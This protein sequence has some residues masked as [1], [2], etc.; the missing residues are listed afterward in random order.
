MHCPQCG[1][2]MPEGAKFCGVCGQRIEAED[3]TRVQGAPVP[4]TASQPGPTPSPAPVQPIPGYAAPTPPYAAPMVEA[5]PL[6]RAWADFRASFTGAALAKLMLISILPV[7]NLCNDGLYLRWGEDAVH[8]GH[9]PVPREMLANGDFAWG[10]KS[11]LVGFVWPLIGLFLLVVPVLGWVLFV[12]WLALVPCIGIA[13]ALRAY[14]RDDLAAGFDFA[15]V[16]RG[17][18]RRFGQLW[19]TVFLPSLA[20]FGIML[21][22]CL[23]FGGVL[24]GSA[25]SILGRVAYGSSSSLGSVMGLLGSSGAILLLVWIVSAVVGVI[26][27]LVSYRGVGYWIARNVPEWPAGGEVPVPAKPVVQQVGYA[28]QAPAAPVAPSPQPEAAP[29]APVAPVSPAP[30]APAAPEQP[31]DDVPAAPASSDEAASPDQGAQ[32]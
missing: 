1:A 8:G 11:V 3:A 7:L 30:E 32:A 15:S 22:V 2:E 25:A 5:S 26:V 9:A 28:P 13:A 29:A 20:K 17:A 14:N 16:W 31:T 27:K 23:L 4:P 19:A 10:F 6:S 12:I 24:L 18:K 21:L